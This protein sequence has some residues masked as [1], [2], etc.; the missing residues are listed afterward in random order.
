MEHTCLLYTPTIASIQHASVVNFR[1]MTEL[2][3]R[4][5]FQVLQPSDLAPADV[6]LTIQFKSSQF[7]EKF[8]FHRSRPVIDSLACKPFGWTLPFC[9]DQFIVAL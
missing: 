6:T 9:A 7:L 5:A 8:M 2:S 3:G 1:A 4:E